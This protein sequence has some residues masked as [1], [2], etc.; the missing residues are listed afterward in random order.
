MINKG[1]R[2]KT[3]SK[4]NIVKNI[5][6]NLQSFLEIRPVQKEVLSSLNLW[7]HAYES[8]DFSGLQNWDAY[9]K[10]N[11]K[12]VWQVVYNIINED[13]VEFEGDWNTFVRGRS[14]QIYISSLNFFCNHFHIFEYDN[15]VI[16]LF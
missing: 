10:A 3:L 13:S 11:A 6:K 1:K 5:S 15:D 8:D 7:D 12:I 9:W 14:F 2:S 16:R 4:V